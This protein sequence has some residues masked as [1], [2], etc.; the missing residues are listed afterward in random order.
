MRRG[1]EQRPSEEPP[2]ARIVRPSITA[3]QKALTTKRAWERQAKRKKKLW[4]KVENGA[5]IV[6]PDPCIVYVLDES[7]KLFQSE[8]QRPS[9]FGE[10]VEVEEPT[11]S[12]FELYRSSP[13]SAKYTLKK[14]IF[15]LG[16]ACENFIND[17][18]IGECVDGYARKDR[19]SIKLFDIGPGVLSSP[20]WEFGGGKKPVK[21]IEKITYMTLAVRFLPS[22]KGP[23]TPYVLEVKEV[24]G[25]K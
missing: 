1:G 17:V 23:G 4:S 8:R 9:E 6:G 11:S 5:R 16:R 21:E 24:I 2:I 20:Q 10:E 3:Q 14:P 12:I 22:G 7:I 13:G 19:T 18:T 25:G 15:L